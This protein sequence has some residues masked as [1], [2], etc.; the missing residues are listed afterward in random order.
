MQLTLPGG[1]TV[2]GTVSAVGAPVEQDD[3]QGGK[4]LKLPLTITLDDPAAA[5][6][7]TTSP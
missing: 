6:G 3:D 7:S 4:K 5:E 2:Q 1:A